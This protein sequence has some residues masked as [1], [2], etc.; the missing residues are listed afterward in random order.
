MKL[1]KQTSLILITL[2]I[3]LLAEGQI[4]WNQGGYQPS[5]IQITPRE[6]PLQQMKQT[7]DI[8]QARY[9][10]NKKYRDDLIDWVT[11][12]RRQTNEE[13]F[14][15]DMKV[16]Y[17]E[18]RAMDGG[19]FH[20]LG[21]DLSTIKRFIDTK[22][23]EYN[24]RMAERPKKLWDDANS[25][26]EKRDYDKAIAL[27]SELISLQPDFIGSYRNRGICY[28]YKEMYNPAIND[29]TKFINSDQTDPASYRARGW[30]Y[31]NLKN[32][33]AALSD[34][35]MQVK[36]K[37]TYEAYYN[38]GSAKSQLNDNVGAI[39]DYTKAINLN[40]NFSMAFNNRGWAKFELKNYTAALTDLNKAIEL[41]PNNSV[42]YDSRQETKFALGDLDGSL[43]DC[44]KALELDPECSNALLFKG[45]IHFKK[46]NKKKACEYWEQ[47][48]N[49]GN[50]KANEYLT[51]YCTQ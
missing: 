38:R 6:V 42:A 44:D 27:Y 9:D 2:S 5:N 16:A 41:D 45:R 8:L 32:L 28:F 22:I 23:D 39:A 17:N 51:K 46:G 37:P 36:I 29:L 35:D 40:P 3:S 21:D 50:E 47:A 13:Q 7:A 25:M 43:S 31:Y 30:S 34:F 14:Q 19:A 1:L 33:N 11:D 20:N 15:K 4:N 10:R 49:L 18:L 24:T 26:L 12:L 48:I